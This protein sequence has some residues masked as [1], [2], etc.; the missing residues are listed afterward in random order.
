[1]NNYW[2]ENSIA[3]DDGDQIVTIRS[4]VKG[5]DEPLVLDFK[6][7]DL[8]PN[9][10]Y[11]LRINLTIDEAKNMAAMLLDAAEHQDKIQRDK[12]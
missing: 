6:N 10:I 11:F 8:P 2:K 4:G 7:C 3:I 1:M 9:C 12:K 5:H